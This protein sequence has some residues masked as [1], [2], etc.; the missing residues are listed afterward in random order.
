MKKNKIKIVY[1]AGPYRGNFFK[2]ILNIWRARKTAQILWNN[3]FGVI[4]PHM[5]SMLFSEKNNDLILNAY[6]ELVK[7]SNVVVLLPGYE[8]SSGTLEE[9]K[10]AKKNKIPVYYS[11]EEF[12]I[13]NLRQK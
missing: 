3:G 11:L 10:I 4:C 12:L 5:N 9:I 6:L 2:K 13:K 7:K 8:K 1:T